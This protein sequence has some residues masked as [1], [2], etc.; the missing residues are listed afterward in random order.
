MGKV[1]SKEVGLEI[2][3]LLTRFFFNSEDLHFG[4]W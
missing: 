2:G 1:D 3:L 4:Y